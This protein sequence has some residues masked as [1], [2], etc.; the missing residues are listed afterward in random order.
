M[1]VRLRP[2]AYD[3][4]AEII[5]YISQQNPSAAIRIV[6]EVEHFCLTSLSDNPRIGTEQNTIV[7]GLRIFLI[8]GYRL[9]YF[10]R[11]DHI[12][13]VRVLHQVR[14][15]PRHLRSENSEP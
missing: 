5:S 3:D 15:L 8:A 9:C 2:R 14:D 11:E 6:D 1:E 4:L 12:D 10:I 7:D 13:V